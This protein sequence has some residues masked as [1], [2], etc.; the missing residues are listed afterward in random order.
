MKTRSR[1][2]L[3]KAIRADGRYAPEAYEF[4][5]EGLEFTTR[6]LF[7]DVDD[8]EARHI[9]GQQLSLGLCQLA[10][11]RW[12]A[13]A[14]VVLRGWN[15]RRTRDFGEMVFFLISLEMMGKQES[16]DIEDFDDVY[17][18]DEVFNSYDL[19]LDNEHE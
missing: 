17:D 12:G 3:L 7:Q 11:L 19:P 13:M 1:E 10:Q 5:H 15:I 14:Q 2:Q 9:S 16:D 6:Q 8:D 18:F 4:L